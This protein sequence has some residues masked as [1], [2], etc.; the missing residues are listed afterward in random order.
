VIVCHMYED[1]MMKKTA[2][3]VDEDDDAK[4]KFKDGDVKDV[5][6]V[7]RLTDKISHGDVMIVC[8]ITMRSCLKMINR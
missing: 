4:Y 6:K 5:D 3:D 8:H 2:T 7:P 1:A